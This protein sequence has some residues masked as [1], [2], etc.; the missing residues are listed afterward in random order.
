MSRHLM[1]ALLP[2]LLFL[3][4]CSGTQKV[5]P[6]QGSGASDIPWNPPLPGENQGAFGVIDRGD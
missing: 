4:A 3:A 5:V 2:P 6:P 1:L